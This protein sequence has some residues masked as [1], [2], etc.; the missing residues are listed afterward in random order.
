MQDEELRE[1]FS[2]WARPLQA[3]VPPAVSV[4]RRRARRRTAR[5]AAACVTAVAVL[6][7]G[8][9]LATSELG[10]S[11]APAA[12][13]LS[14]PPRLGQLPAPDAGAGAAPY[15]LAV[16]SDGSSAGV[17]DAATGKQ[18]GTIA[19][20]A[21][22]S[23]HGSRYP[24]MFTTI[25]AAGDDRT[26]VLGAVPNTNILTALPVWFFE[27]R[28]AAGGSPGPLQPL[29]FPH[30]QQGGVGHGSQNIASIALTA[31]GTKL[32]I[33]TNRTTSG[34][35]NGPADIEVITL[36]T[37]ATRTW[38]STPQA[39]SS[40]SWA[41]DSTLAYA[42]D[43]VCLLDTT[44]PGHDLSQSRLLIPWSTHYRGL[45]GLQWP[46]ITPDGSA[47]YVAM[48]NAPSAIGLVEFSAR[49]GR[50]VRV[51]I[52]PQ[53]TDGGFCGTLWSDPSGQHLTAA[54]TWGAHTGT[55]DNGR[56]TPG[57]TLPPQT[58]GTVTNGAGGDLIAWLCQIIPTP[59]A[60]LGGTSPPRRAQGC[61]P[62]WIQIPRRPCGP[63]ASRGT[64][65]SHSGNLL[66]SKSAAAKLTVSR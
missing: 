25:A 7:A 39:I 55:I 60:L 44:A 46:M 19:A 2:E 26:F 8:G 58:P 37:G 15:Y 57:R 28:L 31:D 54:C 61:R 27:I 41:G 48:E 40:L 43:G 6:A 62:R 35:Q 3:A 29:S 50:P 65:K 9:T 36:A 32:A 21:E 49:T 18:L 56:F 33:A 53:N 38:T 17:W 22:P 13:V 34:D 11:Q 20:P 14:A 47:I 51:V 45:Q 52:Q 42:C 5:V 4:I 1:Q 63:I 12:Q 24:T 30:L 64:P 16:S 59:A 66:G 23:G 10:G